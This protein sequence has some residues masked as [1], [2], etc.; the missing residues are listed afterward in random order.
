MMILVSLLGGLG[1]FVAG[2]NMMSRGVERVAG[3]RLRSVLEAFT[4]TRLLG[5]FVGL[6]FTAMI[7]SSSAAT[8]MVVSFVNSGLMTLSRACGIILGANI[9][10]TVTALLVAFKLSTVAPLFIFTGALMMPCARAA[11]SSWASAFS[12][13]ASARCPLR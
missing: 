12:S 2:M 10:T 1:L 4:K 13:W 3:D 6:F 9:G 8:V 5:L 7:Q 11:R